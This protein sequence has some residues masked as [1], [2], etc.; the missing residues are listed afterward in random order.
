[1][2]NSSGDSDSGL[3]ILEVKIDQNTLFGL[4]ICLCF[5]WISSLGFVSYALKGRNG[6]TPGKSKESD[7]NRDIDTSLNLEQPKE[8]Q[9]KLSNGSLARKYSYRFDEES[10]KIKSSEYSSRG[11]LYF[12]KANWELPD[13]PRNQVINYGIYTGNCGIDNITTLL[14]TFMVDPDTGFLPSQ[15]PLSRLPYARYHV[16]EDIANDLP[17]LLGARLGQARGPLKRMPVISTSKLNSEPELRRAHL[18]LSI[19]AHAYVWGGI[20]PMDVVPEG[21]SKPLSEVCE[22]LGIPPVV[23]HTTICLVNWRRL[24]KE[25][26]ICMENI[27]TLN[28]FF[29]G[30]DESWFYLIHVEIEAKGGVAVVP[31]MMAID[32]IQR[33]N[34][35]SEGEEE[36]EEEENNPFSAIEDKN[37]P[38]ETNEEDILSN[39]MIGSLSKINTATYVAGQLKKISAAIG[40][41]CTSIQ[42]MNEGCYPFIFYHRV[43]PFLSGWKDNPTLPNGVIY[44]NCYGNERQSFVGASAAQSPLIPFFDIALG[45][46]HAANPKSASSSAFLRQMRQYMTKP[47]RDFLTHMEGIACIREFVV[48]MLKEN[49][50]SIDK[51]EGDN[52]DNDFSSD[53]PWI[54]LK[55]SYNDCLMEMRRF[56][57]CHMKLVADYIIAQQSNVKKSEAGDSKTKLGGKLEKSAGGKGTG[58]TGLMSFLKPIRDNCGTSALGNDVRPRNRETEKVIDNKENHIAPEVQLEQEESS[59]AYKK[60]NSDAEDLDVYRSSS[61]FGSFDPSHVPYYKVNSENLWEK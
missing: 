39:V 15:E 22:K 32:A 61:N 47:H 30:R 43:R 29:D 11:A 56:R 42:A 9:K 13:A 7:K 46:S 4:V 10:P 52:S 33:F 5:F 2:S 26:D 25:A 28:N 45:I 55:D 53:S 57:T 18:L 27:S 35:N 23:S 41:M 17:K 1:M 19:M 50:I 6:P 54:K 48:D 20:E 21:I 31:V 44:E 49:G 12:Q 59:E 16:W 60:A 3:G 58:G 37:I 34:E 8:L 38:E 24:D 36:E 14:R 51:E 40:N